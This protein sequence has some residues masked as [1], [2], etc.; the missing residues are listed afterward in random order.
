M[1]IDLHGH[2][3]VIS[4]STA[5]IGFAIAKGLAE[6]GAAVVINGRGEGAVKE[7][8]RQLVETLAGASV[9]G[10]AADL[11]TS[12]GVTQF[13]RRAGNGDI[14][15]NNLGIFEPRP[16]EQITDADWHASLKPT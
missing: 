2:R 7:A 13:L 15:V 12:D 10:I 11:A 14:L 4:G 3:A 5:G 1:K 9:E 8:V 16:F 6:A